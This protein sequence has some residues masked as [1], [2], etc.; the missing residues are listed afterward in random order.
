MRIL[1]RALV[2]AIAGTTLLTSCTAGGTEPR[3]SPSPG[4]EG[5]EA[6]GAAAGALVFSH[7]TD[8][9][10]CEIATSDAD[11]GSFRLLTRNDFWAAN[12][13]RSPTGEWIAFQRD[14]GEDQGIYVM[15]SSGTGLRRVAETTNDVAALHPCWVDE[16]TVGFTYGNSFATV[17][18]DDPEVTEHGKAHTAECGPGGKTIVFPRRVHKQVDGGEL[19]VR[20]GRRGRYRRTLQAGDRRS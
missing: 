15:R 20:S 11:G 1:R 2:A 16:D 7:C 17:S 14:G 9:H 3:S 19:V 4:I 5:R 8:Q 13:A 10:H 6:S 12:P 18:L